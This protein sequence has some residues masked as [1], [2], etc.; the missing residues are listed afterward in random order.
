[1]PVERLE[2]SAARVERRRLQDGSPRHHLGE[3]CLGTPQTRIKGT[4]FLF[5]SDVV[6]GEAYR[7]PM[8][9]LG[10]GGGLR[11]D[12]SE[13]RGTL[14]GA[15]SGSVEGLNEAIQAGIGRRAAASQ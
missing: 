7:L 5:W 12:L 1:M 15:F 2:E 11:L 13:D 3:F 9:I 4:F 10:I 6:S 8:T 14:E